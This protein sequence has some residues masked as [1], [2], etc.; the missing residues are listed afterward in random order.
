MMGTYENIKDYAVIGNGRSAALISRKGS[1]DWLC[2]PRFDSPSLFGA[3]LDDQKGGYWS[4]APDCPYSVNRQYIENSMV[5]KTIFHCETGSA[6]LI[7]CMP[8]QGKEVDCIIP[9]QQIIRI[10]ECS[11]GFVPFQI[12]LKPAPS[13]GKA[14]VKISRNSY[15][16]KYNWNGRSVLFRS[17]ID[18]NENG[19]GLFTLKANQHASMTLSFVREGPAVIVPLGAFLKSIVDETIREWNRWS[20]KCRY[21]GAYKSEVVRSALVLKSLIYSPSGAIV[22][23]PT[24]SLP[25]KLQSDLNWDYRYC[26]LRDASLTVRALYDIGYEQEA[27]AFASWLIHTTRLTRP[28]LRVYYDVY[29]GL[30][31]KEINIGWFK[32]Y[33][34]SRPVRVGNGAR[35][36]LQLDIYGEVI[37]AVGHIIES[38]KQTDHE[39]ESMILDFGIYICKNWD[40]PDEGIWEPRTGR[41]Q[42]I[43]SKVTSYTGLN[44]LVQLQK[45]NL[46]NKKNTEIFQKNLKMIRESVQKNGWNENESSYVQQCGSSVLDMNSLLLAYHNFEDPAGYRMLKTYEA[47]KKKLYAGNGLFYRNEQSKVKKEGTF[48]ICSFWAIEYLARGGGSIDDAT[49]QFSALLAQANDVGLYSEEIEPQTLEFLGNFPQAFTHIGL[50]NA[51]ISIQERILRGN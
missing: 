49:R 1:I 4:I 30:S 3:L 23:A 37:D 10:I 50:I 48:G 21:A 39:T 13:F 44:R 22:A 26:W 46:I 35:G 27:M 6:S 31:G 20:Q 28:E 11:K 18:L 40:K 12:M 34:N 19:K 36:Q 14:S 9:E 16:I 38:Q 29:G 15:G 7:D 47:L 8:I 25:E 17:E 33:K 45:R 42:H 5:L 41:F 32:G 51:A 2:W 43:H 24:T